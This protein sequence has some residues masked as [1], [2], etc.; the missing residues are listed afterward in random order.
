[1]IQTE[2][3]TRNDCLGIKYC[4]Q[5]TI[6]DTI[7]SNVFSRHLIEARAGSFILLNSDKS[8]H[9]NMQLSCCR[10]FWCLHL[11]D[12]FII[13]SFLL[14]NYS[15]QVSDRQLCQ[16]CFNLCFNF[17]QHKCYCIGIQN[18]NEHSEILDYYTDKAVL[19]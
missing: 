10:F 3:P 6:T 15:L 16:T 18:C 2:S 12:I 11:I 9:S 4:S 8:N 17:R 7:A 13:M 19:R 5:F 1:M 14:T